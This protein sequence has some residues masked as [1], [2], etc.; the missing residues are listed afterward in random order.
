ME[1]V[2][3]LYQH[4]PKCGG[5]SFIRACKQ[6]FPAL[7]EK[8][9]SYPT[10]ERIAEFARTRRTF[11]ELAPNTFLHGHLVNEG[12]RPFE[13]YGDYI[14][15]GKFRVLTIVRDP[16]E[17]WISAYF[18]RQRVGKEWPEPLE[19]WLERGHNPFARYFEVDPANWR[20][21]MDRY[22]LVGTTESMQLTTDLFAKKTGQPPLETPHLNTS[23]RSE[24]ALSEELQQAFREKHA[25][26]Y[27]IYN[28][29]TERLAREAAEHG[30]A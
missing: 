9:G 25:L 8:V 1:K 6:W 24:Y 13:R 19:K 16:L 7:R 27:Q 12:I 4:I 5:I 22:F 18:H 20:A 29:A 15:E 21:Q 14:A 26:D 23:P 10:P 2:V 3:Y 11:E 28:Y 17:R 30:L